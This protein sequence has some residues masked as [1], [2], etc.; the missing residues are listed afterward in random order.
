[1]DVLSNPILEVDIY[2]NRSDAS[3][4][5]DLQVLVSL[6]ENERI[7]ATT[8]SNIET[9]PVSPEIRQADAGR[10]QGSKAFADADD[11]TASI[12]LDNL[13]NIALWELNRPH[14]YTVRVQLLD[15][16]HVIDDYSSRIGFREARFTR[17]GFMLNGKV[18]KLRG[19]DRH[20]T[21]PWVGQAMPA[22]VQQRDAYILRR[23]HYL[24]LQDHL[25]KCIQNRRQYELR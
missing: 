18:I 24:H 22:R 20:Q 1:L 15:D 8:L 9:P 4:P 11:P 13:K 2:L 16:G 7:V 3:H 21:F 6:R 14:L 5:R 17:D 23:D 19:L 10:A 25:H 12:R